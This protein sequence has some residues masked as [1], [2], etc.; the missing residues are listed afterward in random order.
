LNRELKEIRKQ[1]RTYVW[2]EPSR[3]GKYKAQTILGIQSRLGKL[4]KSI[5]GGNN[6]G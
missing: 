6:R 1:D 2:K 4:E 3:Q 5:G